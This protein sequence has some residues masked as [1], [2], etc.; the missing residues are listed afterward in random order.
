M[1]LLPELGFGVVTLAS[2]DGAYFPGTLVTALRELPALPPPAAAPDVAPDP[3]TFAEEVGVYEDPHAVGTVT[4][5]LQ[6]GQLRVEAPAVAALGIAYDPVLQ[7]ISPRNF[8]ITIRGRQ[9]A[10]TFIHGGAGEPTLRT[11]LF[12]AERAPAAGLRARGPAP[13]A[14]RLGAALR[15]ARAPVLWP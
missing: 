14:E 15:A 12:V 8:L 11:R 9:Y 6:G 2:G 1:F 13:S 7:P 10:L 4:V 3:S 5:S